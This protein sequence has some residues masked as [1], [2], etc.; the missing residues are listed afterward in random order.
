[1]ESDGYTCYYFVQLY[2]H[3]KI[4]AC[5]LDNT[6][7]C[8]RHDIHP[9]PNIHRDKDKNDSWM[10]TIRKDCQSLLQIQNSIRYKDYNVQKIRMLPDED[11][12]KHHTRV[13]NNIRFHK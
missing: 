3:S 9:V 8:N 7:G 12:N 1:M 11:N 13:Y 10:K 2:N 6:H 5:F 4:P